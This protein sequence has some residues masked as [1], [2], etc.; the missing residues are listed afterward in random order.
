MHSKAKDKLTEF[1]R[2]ILIAL[3]LL[4]WG[5]F[6]EYKDRAFYRDVISTLS[7][8]NDLEEM[9]ELYI[10]RARAFAKIYKAEENEAN[11]ENLFHHLKASL[12]ASG[13]NPTV[14]MPVDKVQMIKGKRVKGKRGEYFH[15]LHMPN[16]PEELLTERLVDVWLIPFMVKEIYGKQLLLS[17]EVWSEERNTFVALQLLS[18]AIGSREVLF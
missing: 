14:Q 18:P 15:L 16:S 9:R 13:W 5:L 17:V 4:L 2:L 6:L 7:L 11:P 10:Y 8:P 12:G 1:T 3:P